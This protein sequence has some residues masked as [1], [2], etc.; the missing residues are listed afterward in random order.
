MLAASKTTSALLFQRQSAILPSHGRVFLVTTTLSVSISTPKQMA[1]AIQ[2]SAES[3][4]TTATAERILITLT[5]TQLPTFANNVWKTHNAQ[6]SSC[7]NAGALSAA[8]A[9][10]MI[11]VL[12]SI[13][14]WRLDTAS[15]EIRKLGTFTAMEISAMEPLAK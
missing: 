2:E 10:L 1:G 13:L 4:E 11:F 15:M 14:V 5:A 3:A 9:P 8:L 6:A 12:S 7:Q